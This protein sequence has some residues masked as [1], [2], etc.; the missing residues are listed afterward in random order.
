[1]SR[2]KH[3]FVTVLLIAFTTNITIASDWKNDVKAIDISG[4]E[5]HTL[6]LT[7][8]KVPWA[9]GHNGWY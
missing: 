5:D 6:V 9:C 8:N 4:G 3:T 7:H 1:M 2:M